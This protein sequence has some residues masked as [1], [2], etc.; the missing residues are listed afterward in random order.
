MKIEWKQGTIGMKFKYKVLQQS[1]RK[2]QS[3]R[4]SSED[5]IDDVTFQSSPFDLTVSFDIK[6]RNSCDHLKV[7][8]RSTYKTAKFQR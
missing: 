8:H 5:H 2:S 1:P 3:T 7:H 6:S 4:G